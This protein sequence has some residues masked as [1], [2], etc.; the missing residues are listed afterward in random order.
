MQSMKLALIGACGVASLGLCSVAAEAAP[1]ASNVTPTLAAAGGAPSPQRRTLPTAAG[2]ATASVIAAA[3]GRTIAVTATATTGRFI[4]RPIG[5]V[6]AVGG[7]KW[8]AT[9][10]AVAA[11]RKARD[12]SSLPQPIVSDLH[13][14]RSAR[15]PDPRRLR[16]P[17]TEGMTLEQWNKVLSINLCGQFL[18]ARAAAREFRRRGDRASD[19]LCRGKDHQHELGASSVASERSAGR[20]ALSQ[21]ALGQ[22]C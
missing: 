6:Q 7:R 12:Q 22:Q 15:T 1:A 4:R 10:A 20:R 5:P 11:V 19:F 17:Q 3:L 13:G 2:G 16:P 14:V 21:P 18:C 9:I 8:I